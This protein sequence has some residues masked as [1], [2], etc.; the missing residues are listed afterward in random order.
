MWADLSFHL[1]PTPKFKSHQKHNRLDDKFP[2]F[3]SGGELGVV[4]QLL[5]LVRKKP[6]TEDAKATLKW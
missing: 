2:M 6:G 4:R 3:G 5:E 1:S